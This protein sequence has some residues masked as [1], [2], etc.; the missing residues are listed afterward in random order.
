VPTGD[1]E[2][3]VAGLN[4]VVAIGIGGVDGGWGGEPA[5]ENGCGKEEYSAASHSI[6]IGIASRNLQREISIPE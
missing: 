1:P 6:A 3:R 5:D 4:H 2:Q